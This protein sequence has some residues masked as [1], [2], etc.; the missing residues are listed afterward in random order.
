[1]K[2]IF[3]K[4]T[5]V[6]ITAAIC[7]ILVINAFFT[8]GSIILQQRKTFYSKINQIINTLENR[9][10]ESDNINR[11]LGNEYLTRAKAAAYVIEKDPSVVDSVEEL[12]YLADLLSVDELHIIDSDG[13]LTASSVPKYIGLNFHDDEQTSPFLT[14]LDGDKDA[15]FIQDSI[16]N[17]AEDKI[18]KYVG[19]ARQDEKGIVQVGLSP[20]RI[21]EST[22]NATYD[23]IFNSFPTD[24]G[25][26][27]FVLD[28]SSGELLGCSH[29][30]S[31]HTLEDSVPF[32]KAVQASR[33][34]FIKNEQYSWS[35]LLSQ[36]YNDIYICASIPARI[37]IQNLAPNV[38][39]N[40]ICLIVIEIIILLLLNY[41]LES[42]VLRGIHQILAALSQITIGNLDTQVAVGGNPEF[43][44]LSAK[45]NT[46]VSSISHTTDRITKIIEISQ[47]PLAA[48]EYQKESNYL[49]VTSGTKKLLH[50]T[51]SQ[52]ERLF[53]DPTLFYQYIQQILKHP[54]ED[55]P[56]VYPVDNDHFIHIHL[57]SESSGYLG[58][59]TDATENIKRKRKMFFENTHDP[60][61]NLY[62][63]QYFKK[64]IQKKL[65]NMLPGRLCSCVMLDLDSFKSINDTY[66]HDTGD[67]YLKHFAKI[68][69]MLPAQ[70]CIVA[71]RS[72]DEFCFFT[73]GHTSLDAL[74]EC[75]NS[76]WALLSEHPLSLPDKE[77]KI[78]GVSGGLAWTSHSDMDLDLLLNYADKALYE[79]KEQH[80]GTLMEY[81]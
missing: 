22:G 76:F 53:L 23:E 10:L 35:Y 57:S 56:D 45:I 24:I 54:A 31:A 1:M 59:I 27:F 65:T 78:I 39:F 81:H 68:M 28:A 64:L 14:I 61:T 71:R 9:A 3:R 41:L 26:T 5:S 74:R 6:I 46:M 49:F 80:K 70:H 52:A 72:G 62:R 33:G 19:V 32:E 43:E 8:A 48:F 50:L 20:L 77:Q 58:V 69:Q 63:Y 12:Q 17:A 75:V 47:I 55:E 11:T 29:G 36:R 38:L 4:Y 67:L 25:E 30:H 44:E 42:K 2:K 21:A 51:D 40:F 15:Y 7:L 73:Y 16:P 60:L 18:M 66:G 79:A 37:L 34:S 13:I